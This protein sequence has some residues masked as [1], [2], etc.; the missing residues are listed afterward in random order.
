MF[1]IIE[2]VENLP[3]GGIKV[4][5]LQFNEPDVRMD[6]L[7]PRA[8]QIASADQEW[9]PP[10]LH[11]KFM[12]LQKKEKA[13]KRRDEIEAKK[14]DE[15]QPLLPQ[16][17]ARPRAGGGT[18]RP[19]TGPYY[20]PYGGAEGLRGTDTSRT[21]PRRGRPDSR[22][23]GV[24][25]GLYGD[26]AL[27][28][29]MGRAGGRQPARGGP[30]ARGRDE[31]NVEMDYLMGIEASGV[32]R[33]PST[34]DIYYEFQDILITE[35]TDLSK[36]RQPLVFWAH[37]DMIEPGKNYRYRIRLG[38]F[39]PIAGAKQAVRGQGSGVRK[40][41]PDPRSPNPELESQVILWSGFSDITSSVQIP[42]RLYFFAK[43]IQEA[44]K[45]VTVQVSKYVLGYWYSENFA[46]RQGEA[47]G[48]VVELEPEASSVPRSL[49]NP[50]LREPIR[51]PSV[52]PDLRRLEYPSTRLGPGLWPIDKPTEPQSIDYST[53]AVLVDAVAV[54]D[55]STAGQ[56][57]PRRYFDMFYS[58][59]GTNIEHMPINLANWSANLLAAY[60]EI[61]RLQREPKEPLRAWDSRVAGP[62]QRAPIMEG[63]EDI[64]LLYEEMMMEQMMGGEMR[65]R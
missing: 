38:V 57:R 27:Y 15:Q 21:R 4:R 26:T 36:W 56:M 53:G 31:R 63:Y 7:Q 40:P 1:E 2:D 33:K 60:N 64:D 39:N 5:L 51:T 25:M 29:D 32:P 61:N 8:Y 19:G 35:M 12:E 18:T 42:E 46:V 10:L 50:A 24:D 44:A 62:R 54:N 52:R 20:Q 34:N 65:R 23:G 9:F 47:I 48:K 43:D 3:P 30:G 28:G 17:Q 6:L 37:D 13:E 49:K 22:T 45:M 41:I 16:G 11:R 55:W 59:D 58:F 14:Q